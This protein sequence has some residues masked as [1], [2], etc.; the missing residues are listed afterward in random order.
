MHLLEPWVVETVLKTQNH[1]AAVCYGETLDNRL[2]IR[3]LGAT[4]RHETIRTLTDW[5]T[6]RQLVCTETT[7]RLAQPPI[8]N[9]S[10]FVGESCSPVF[11]SNVVEFHVIADDEVLQNKV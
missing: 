4:V 1:H 11:D 8:Q 9:Y 2:L 10:L 5:A 3:I 6:G 7:P